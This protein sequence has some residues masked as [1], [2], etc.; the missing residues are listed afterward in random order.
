MCRQFTKF[1]F[2]AGRCGSYSHRSI[3]DD[4]CSPSYPFNSGKP[5]SLERHGARTIH[6]IGGYVGICSDGN[7]ENSLDSGSRD[8]G[9]ICWVAD[10]TTTKHRDGLQSPGMKR[11]GASEHGTGYTK[12]G[13]VQ[14]WEHWFFWL[15]VL[16]VDDVI[17]VR[18]VRTQDEVVVTAS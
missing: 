8:S 2:R 15:E 11:E 10:N 14:R 9:P 1:D 16:W 13:R 7:W 17:R 5:L 3:S 12:C 6:N 18:D 4:V